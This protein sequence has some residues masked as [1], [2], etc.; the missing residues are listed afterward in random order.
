MARKRPLGAVH[1]A[2]LV[3]ASMVGTG[4]FTITGELLPTLPSPALVLAAWAVP[5]ARA[6]RRGRVRGAGNDDAARGRRVRLPVAR[7]R[8]RHRIHVGLG[9]VDRRFRGAHRGRG[10][11]VRQ[12]RARG[13]AGAAADG[14]RGGAD[15]GRHRGAHAGREAGRAG[16][17]RAGGAGRRG[18][19]VVRGGGARDRAPRAARTWRPRCRSRGTRRAAASPR[20]RVRSLSRS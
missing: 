9:R 11:R 16:A 20:A 3:V 17:G 1:A 12:L 4:V 10:A 13:R 7:V 19:R 8:P 2:A 18:H 5:A 14:G 15:R 6:V